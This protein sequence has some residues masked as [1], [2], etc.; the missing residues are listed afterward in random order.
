MQI[1]NIEKFIANNITKRNQSF[2]EV[3]IKGNKETLTKEIEGKT[4]LV[5]G[6]AG[7]IGSSYVKAILHFNPAVVYVVDTNEN[8]LTELIRDVR[9]DATYTT[10]PQLLTYPIDFDSPVFYKLFKKQN[11]FDIV[12]NFAAHK[13]VRS[14]KDEFSIEAMVENNVLKA[15]RFL[16]L[17]ISFPP[18]HFFCVSTDKAANPVNLMGATKKL[19]EEVIMAYANDFKIT[20]AR[21]ANVAFS[22]G[23]LLFGFLERIAKQQPLSAPSDVKRYFVSPKES[24]ELC[25]LA[26][27]LGKSA[28]IFFP[29]LKEDEMQTFS[30][31]GN[32]LLSDFGFTPDHCTT[33][34]EAKTKA[35]QLTKESTT[36]PVYYFTSDTD[37]EKS[38]EEFFT[39]KETLD[40]DRFNNLGV[41]TNYPKKSKADL[42][43]VLDQIENLFNTNDIT[44][45]DII[46]MIKNIIPNFNHITT[47]KSLDNRM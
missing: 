45:T 14:E 29:K 2:F 40:S 19:M 43:V 34:L 26:C 16:D 31:I 24:G 10:L 20:T 33:E 7:T 22:N 3:D 39:D 15:K 32:L 37:G 1:F 11:G 47:G 8:G 6:G 18:K 46:E 17:L 35:N 36:Y 25:M 38:F 44:K 42:K 23:S 28:E 5:I 12:A 30:S 27:I 9:S 13:H 21:F 4:I 41:V